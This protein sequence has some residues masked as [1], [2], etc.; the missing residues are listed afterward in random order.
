[1]VS[2]GRSPLA[3][4][5]LPLAAWEQHTCLRLAPPPGHVQ[6]R[7]SDPRAHHQ[8]TRLTEARRVRLRAGGVGSG[9]TKG[10]CQPATACPGHH[11]HRSLARGAAQ[12]VTPWG[13]A[14]P[15]ATLCGEEQALKLLLGGGWGSGGRQRAPRGG[16][17]PPR[18]GWGTSETHQRGRRSATG[19]Q[20][21]SRG[22][23]P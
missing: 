5:S 3:V 19:T 8:H 2:A 22:Y 10:T 23:R 16:G 7:S 14:G 9:G 18:I 11:T 20:G 17:H 21:L 6:K 4:P 1:M 12:R 13:P 15:R